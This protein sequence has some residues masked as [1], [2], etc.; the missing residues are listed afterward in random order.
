MRCLLFKREYSCSQRV[1]VSTTVPLDVD[2]SKAT[3]KV[4]ER[5]INSNQAQFFLNGRED[6]VSHIK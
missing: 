6:G 1:V 2:D 5:T 3:Q 4:D